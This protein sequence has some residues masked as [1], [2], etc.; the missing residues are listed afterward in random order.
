MEHKKLNIEKS[1]CSKYGLVV[2]ELGACAKGLVLNSWADLDFVP[3]S[4][5]WFLAPAAPNGYLNLTAWENIRNS[6]SHIFLSS[7]EFCYHFSFNEASQQKKVEKRG[8]CRMRGVWRGSA[9]NASDM[10]YFAWQFNLHH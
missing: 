10:R 9:P 5:A 7:R 1:E 3:G 2:R 6:L 4:G 8:V